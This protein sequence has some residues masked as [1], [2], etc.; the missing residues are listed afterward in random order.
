M[1]GKGRLLKRKKINEKVYK[2]IHAGVV[3]LKLFSEE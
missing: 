2:I 1:N 3:Q